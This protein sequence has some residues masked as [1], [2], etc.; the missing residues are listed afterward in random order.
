MPKVFSVYDD[1]VAAFLTPMTFETE[2]QAIRSFQ[3]AVNSGDGMI[4]KHPG[5]FSFYMLGYFNEASGEFENEKKF[6]VS[7]L[8]VRLDNRV[9]ELAQQQREVDEQIDIEQMIGEEH[10]KS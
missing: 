7:A 9:E 10:G 3:D 2:G 4:S 6:V 1:K 8:Q 5:D